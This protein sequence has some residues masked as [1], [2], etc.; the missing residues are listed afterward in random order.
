[1]ESR[2]RKAIKSGKFYFFDPGV[3]HTLAGTR[4]LDRNSDLYGKSF[5]QFIGMEI[6]AYLSHSRIRLPFTYWR[7][8]HGNE[9]D[10]L[11]GERTAV[12]AKATTRVVPRDFKGLKALAEE[13]V[14]TDLFLVSQD[15]LAARQANIQAIYW[16]D[17]LKR[18]WQG[19]I[20]APD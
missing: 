8:T 11:I 4:V 13:R 3:T 9:V 18:L 5:E 16:E 2:K 19:G 14:F 20:I 17:F 15:K 10:F 6:R 1:M 7:S 12:E